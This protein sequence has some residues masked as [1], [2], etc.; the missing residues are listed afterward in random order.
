MIKFENR[1][2][3]LLGIEG[4]ELCGFTGS[5]FS[6]CTPLCFQ[7]QTD[8]NTTRYDNDRYG[9]TIEVKDDSFRT[10]P[11][12][13]RRLNIKN[14][15][16]NTVILNKVNSLFVSGI[17][18]G[19]QWYEKG[20]FLV[21]Y[22][23][24]CWQGEFQWK[25]ADLQDFSVYPFSTH[26]N[27][28]ETVF[29]SVGSWNTLKH[30]PMLLLED[31]AEK[32]TYIFEIESPD[33]W[34]IA[35]GN[36]KEE[37]S[38]G[39]I[40]VCLSAANMLNDGWQMALAPGEEY[41]AAPAVYG[42]VE[43]GIN[44]ALAALTDYKRETVRA[45]WPENRIPVIYNCYMNGIWSN[46]TEENL[47][48]LI[49]AA[50]EAGVEI[51]CID[52]GWHSPRDSKQTKGIGD[53]EESGSR[54]ENMGLAGIIR[55]IREKGMQA[56]IWMELE[57]VLSN[58][59]AANL[60]EDCLLRRNGKV[61]GGSRNLFDFRQSAVI[62]HL[63][64]AIDRLYQM[65]VRY[66]KNDFNQTAGIGFDAP[67]LCRSE[68]VRRNS[69]AFLAFMDTVRRK[70]PDLL[71]E[72]CGSGGLRAGHAVLSGF[73]IQS[74][75]DQELYQYMPSIAAGSVLCMPPE[76]AGIWCMPYPVRYND[77]FEKID[78]DFI[79]RHFGGDMAKQT[80]FNLS[81]AFLGAVY[82]GG[83]IDLCDRESKAILKD[84]VSAYQQVRDIIAA[85]HP[86]VIDR[87]ISIGEKRVCAAAL[88]S[89]RHGKAI[90]VVW[91]I[92]DQAAEQ[93]VDLSPL[94]RVDA[95]TPLCMMQETTRYQFSADSLR[96]RFDKGLSAAAF[97]ADIEN[98]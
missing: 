9:L 87:W 79:N 18:E 57:A 94:G 97:L 86:V 55:L 19:T 33:S 60:S 26:Q 12:S 48:P 84:A 34:S 80:V 81:T 83:R 28:A 42:A 13:R 67:G 72:N 35:I 24:C 43:G 68:A 1:V 15:G 25:I 96:V 91:N 8:V 74:I 64:Q 31:T 37:L 7:P 63:E 2:D 53:W 47:P 41:T 36:L 46:P 17:G 14:S 5:S 54:F 6:A 49:E 21:H 51:F 90:V 93:T 62:E 45:A 98:I 65:G 70:Y 82:L 89:E 29:S 66:I 3:R 30:Y 27:P 88:I 76:K 50:A 71:I 20:R 16:N 78:R 44:E 11:L 58:C 38:D 56:G 69:S 10:T 32:R 85:A 39:G 95:V 22:T 61:I 59:K 4:E 40:S 73:H 92:T 77:R 75:T 23:D 52:A